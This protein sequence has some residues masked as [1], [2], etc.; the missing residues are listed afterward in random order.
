ML[1]L[2]DRNVCKAVIAA[3]FV[4]I[5]LVIAFAPILVFRIPDL[6]DRQRRGASCDHSQFALRRWPDVLN[7]HL[8]LYA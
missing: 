6:R 1:V 4:K 7:E 3:P 5:L 2:I 8:C